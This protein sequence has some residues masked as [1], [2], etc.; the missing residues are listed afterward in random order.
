MSVPALVDELRQMCKSRQ[1]E[2][3]WK[4]CGELSAIWTEEGKRPASDQVR[5]VLLI[6]YVE[7]S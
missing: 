2:E 6:V 7:K 3:F 5:F 4:R 1:I